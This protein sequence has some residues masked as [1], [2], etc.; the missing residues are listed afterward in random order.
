MD[1]THALA[2]GYRLTTLTA[3][4]RLS[5]ETPAYSATLT[6]EGQEVAEVTSDGGGGAPLA[7]FRAPG[8][9]A[10]FEQTA[11]T[12]AARPGRPWLYLPPEEELISVLHLHATLA[13]DVTKEARTH[14]VIQLPEDGDFWEGGTYRAIP[15]RGMRRADVLDVVQER[16][17][18]V[19]IWDTTTATFQTHTP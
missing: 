9:R 6:H 12:L 3:H 17:P 19:R 11:R 5:R 7:L 13:Q 2:T 16:Y 8:D 18:E 1:L 15:L 4:P 10:A 14:L